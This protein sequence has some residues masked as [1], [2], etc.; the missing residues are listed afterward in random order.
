MSVWLGRHG[1][2]LLAHLLALAP[3]TWW[4]LR[5]LSGML[6]ADPVRY[7]MLRSGV[8]GI[9][10]LLAALACTP[11]SAL[12]GWRSAVQLRRPLGLYAV[13][14]S[15]L[16]LLIY[17]AFDGGLDWRLI[18]RDLAERRAMLVGLAALLL[19]VPLAL[20]STRGWQCRLGKRW[21]TLHTLVYVAAPLSVLHVYWLDRDIKTQAL[22]YAATVGVLLLL[23]LPP[24]R[25][26]LVRLR[27]GAPTPP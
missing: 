10:A 11:L 14:Y 8:V 5:W 23:R 7:L 21:R 20:T 2:R 4:S 1:Q 9:V 22:L 6:P 18:A 24:L 26:A 15:A 16:H 19:L 25:R 13:F 27:Q 12:A 17:A 3:L